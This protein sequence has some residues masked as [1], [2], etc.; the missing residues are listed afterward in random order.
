MLPDLQLLLRLTGPHGVLPN[1][2]TY[3]RHRDAHDMRALNQGPRTRVSEDITGTDDSGVRHGSRRACAT[4]VR[5][6]RPW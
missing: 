6:W 1:E 3:G 2:T 4:G 5:P